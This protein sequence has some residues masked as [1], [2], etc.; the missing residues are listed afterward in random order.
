M[1]NQHFGFLESPFTTTPNSRL[2]YSNDLYREALANLRYGI[3]WRKGLI[4]MTGEVGTGKTT[5]LCKIMRGLE[6]TVHPIFVSY[7][8]LTSVELLRMIARE[9]GLTYDAQ[10]RL[11]T[12]GQL[13]DYLLAKHKKAETVALLIDE[14]QNLSDDMF[15]DIRFLSNIETETEK[16]LQIV[17]TGQP[18]LETRL[19]QVHLR[20]VRQRVVVHCRLAA[21]K[22]DEVGHYIAV[23]LREAGYEGK[24]LFSPEVVGEIAL[25][26]QGIPR[27]INIIC[28]NALL[29]AYAQSQNKVR[30]EMVHEVVRDLGLTKQSPPEPAASPRASVSLDRASSAP[31][32]SG[33]PVELQT[34][35]LSRQKIGFA[36]IPAGVS[37]ALV[38]I[39][40]AGGSFS[41][42]PIKGYFQQAPASEHRAPVREDPENSLAPSAPVAAAPRTAENLKSQ[43]VKLEASGPKTDPVKP[44]NN[45]P[46]SRQKESASGNF[47]V[48]GQN[49]FVR[50]T[51]RAD[52]K[53]IATLP[54][55]TQVK[56]VSVRGNYLRVQARVD[57]QKVGGYVHREDA[58]FERI[59]PR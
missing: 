8:H 30:M 29:L 21:L 25:Y 48:T 15:E 51:P 38:A 5:L 53:I 17:L 19:G 52:G 7:D 13:R 2:F 1:Y 37:L 9:L 31:M 57:G 32:G 34:R 58:F 27:L 56:V 41:S 40:S 14:A 47:Q 54:P 50:G 45:R 12:I 20:H 11:A 28:D 59:L 3:E 55:G 42:W 46:A 10:D 39:G 6:A 35:S 23:R 33:H 24:I 36:L 18:E 4:V 44:K 43:R 26:S 49:S 22:S 16:L